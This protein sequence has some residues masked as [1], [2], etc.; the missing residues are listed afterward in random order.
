MA[1]EPSLA[2][3]LASALTSWV[4]SSDVE[5]SLAM[6]LDSALESCVLATVPRLMVPVLAVAV[7]SALASWVSS[8]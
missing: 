4:S 1:K 2:V 7:A 5:A 8:T 3:A 6:A